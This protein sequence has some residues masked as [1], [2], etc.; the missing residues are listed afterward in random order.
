MTFRV[1]VVEDEPIVAVN[2]A[3]VLRQ[4]R[5]E[6]VG[7]V[8]TLEHALEVIEREQLSG[9]VIDLD[10]HGRSAAPILTAL[11]QRDLP[12]VIVS[13]LPP[14]EVERRVGKARLLSKPCKAV[15]LI[16]A[17]HAFSNPTQPLSSYPT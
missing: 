9:A 6:V 14:D 10:L 3:T 13:G 11:T 17:V 12:F 16:E 8:G 5:I 7:P 2:Y 1:L 4:A 15:E